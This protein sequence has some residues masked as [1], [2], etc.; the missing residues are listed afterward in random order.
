[1]AY[2]RVFTTLLTVKIFRRVCF[3]KV[4]RTLPTSGNNSKN[5][6]QSQCNLCFCVGLYVRRHLVSCFITKWL[7]SD[8][9]HR[10]VCWLVTNF[11]NQ[12]YQLVLVQKI[13]LDL[14]WTSILT[15]RLCFPHA[16]L[17]CIKIGCLP[18]FRCDCVFKGYLQHGYLWWCVSRK[19][20]GAWYSYYDIWFT[21]Q[22]VFFLT[23]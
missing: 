12:R 23:N 11:N 20:K 19:F 15:P 7:K 3:F 1:M 18:Y 5:P 8:Q 10:N 4:T 16:R 6:R 13:V 9:C 22:L 17:L 2:V 21:T 14:P